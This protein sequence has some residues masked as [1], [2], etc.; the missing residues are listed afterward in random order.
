M[1]RGVIT[2]IWRKKLCRAQA[3]EILLPSISHMGF[4]DCGVDASGFV[5]PVTGKE[6]IMGNELLRKAI[7]SHRMI[8]EQV[9]TCRYAVKL[10]CEELVDRKISELALFDTEG[11][12]AAYKTFYEKGKDNDIELTFYMDVIF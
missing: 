11:D 9:A 6:I 5:I 2:D 1:A 7:E 3:G 4:G 10:M 8:S 12:M